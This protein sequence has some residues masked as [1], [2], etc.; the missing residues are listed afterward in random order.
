M[1]GNSI[2][3]ECDYWSDQSQDREGA[4]PR[5]FPDAGCARRRGDRIA[6][7]HFAPLAGRAATQ[8]GEIDVATD[9]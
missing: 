4:R 3:S 2:L 7:S 5:A 1:K 6:E 8:L 9:N